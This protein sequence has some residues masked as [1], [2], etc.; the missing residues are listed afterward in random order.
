MLPQIKSGNVRALA[1]GSPTRSELLPDVP[2]FAE[3]LGV[4][5]Y[6]VDVWYGIM[7][8]AGTPADVVAKL[9][10]QVG[11]ALENPQLREK[12]KKSGAEVSM[13]PP[14]QFSALIRSDTDKW[15][16]TVNSIGFKALQ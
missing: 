16:R 12:I 8:P 4:P 7:A 14:A 3:E 1:I 10:E 13:L 9:T 2:T 5:D 6:R 11:K 15:T